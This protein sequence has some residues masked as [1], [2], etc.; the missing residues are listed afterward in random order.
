MTQLE[1]RYLDLLEQYIMLRK[2][3]EETMME[4][5]NYVIADRKLKRLMR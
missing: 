4:G 1:T 2:E 5:A 3:F